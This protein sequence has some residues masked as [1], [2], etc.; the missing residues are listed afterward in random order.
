MR[1]NSRNFSLW[2]AKP[3]TRGGLPEAFLFKPKS[4]MGTRNLTMV[5]HK[6][7]TKVA[8]YGQWD[9]YPSGQGATVLEFLKSVNLSLFKERLLKVRFMND[10]DNKEM[11]KFLASIGCSDGWMNSEQSNKFRKKYPLLSRD[12]GAEI[13]NLIMDRDDDG[14][15]FQVKHLKT[16]S[17]SELPSEE[18]FISDLE[19]IEEIEQE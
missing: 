4:I 19:G 5:I 11:D 16:Y 8:Q 1:S 3:R 14:S 9:G 6:A 15:Y 17:L 10:R 7:E 18:Q 12:H 13:L 2:K